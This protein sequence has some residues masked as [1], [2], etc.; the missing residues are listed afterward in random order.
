[1]KDKL[2]FKTK[3]DI[4][5][6]LVLFAS[7]GLYLVTLN[8]SV[9]LYDAGDMTTAAWVLGIPHPPG[10]PFYCLFGN[11]W[12]QLIPIGNIA[13]R[14]NMLSAFSS[15]I[16]IMLIYLISLKIVKSRIPSLISSL[17]LAF[18]NTFWGQATFAGQYITNLFF[19]ILLLFLL[20]K[21]K[22]RL[23]LKILYLFFF[24]LGLSLAHHRQTLFIVPA[25]IL[26]ILA[27]LWKNRKKQFKIQNLKFKIPLTMA[28][29]FIL[30]LTL[31][32]Y[33]PI[34]ASSHP[35]LNWSDPETPD[36]F[37]S[38]IKG[39]QY[40]FLFLK[41]KPKEYIARFINQIRGLFPNE[42]GI[43]L[44]SLGIVGLF[45]MAIKRTSIFLFLLLIFLTDVLISVT[46]N[47]PSFQL[48]Y[49]IPFAIFS[50]W[51]GF[52]AFF[53]LSFSKKKLAYI[54]FSLALLI[55]PIK[56]FISNY[57]RNDHSLYYSPYNY[58]LNIL[59]PIKKNGV[60]IAD[61]DTHSFLLEYFHYC[62]SVRKDIALIEPHQL[63]FE[64]MANLYREMYPDLEFKMYPVKK[65][66]LTY[67]EVR[68]QRIE[69]MIE[70]NME[71]RPFYIFPSPSYPFI[72]RYEFLPS[73]VFS[74]V[75]KND[76][77]SQELYNLL[78]ETDY[79]MKYRKDDND[80]VY[81]I[82]YATSC[83]NRG[84]FISS[85]IVI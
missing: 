61:D 62:E 67:D 40:D 29:L 77:S 69:S 56:L 8:P 11:L 58:C 84:L 18:S 33:L 78:L 27:I 52:G 12:M 47:H 13:Y 59:R 46:Y 37:I 26:F 75:I 20:F 79:K 66:I 38:H 73:G 39:S 74:M 28:L 17:S 57:K 44:L 48:Y 55:I 34:R 49:M 53:I 42:F 25:A 82:N 4:F 60:I 35:P 23:S 45:A 54:I 21:Y 76:I 32:L 5:G 71:R 10:Y 3:E 43:L 16:A 83:F 36:R 80:S 70:M 31:Y 50:L 9:G 7:F 1:M 41:L 85:N 65:A 24:T 72:S 22:E 30:P 68:N 64:W 19:F 63:H 2:G 14:L 81:I 51:I 6:R 15:S